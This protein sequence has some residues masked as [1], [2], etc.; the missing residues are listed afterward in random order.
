MVPAHVPTKAHVPGCRTALPETHSVT[1]FPLNHATKSDFVL[2]KY[3]N[4][5]FLLTTLDNDKFTILGINF[6]GLDN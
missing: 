2:K 6:K 3:A 5:L 1:F 4:T